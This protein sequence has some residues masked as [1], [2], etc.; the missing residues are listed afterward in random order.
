MLLEG[1]LAD[2]RRNSCPSRREMLVLAATNEH[3]HIQL[4]HCKTIQT[5]EENS[6]VFTFLYN[7]HC[8]HTHTC[9]HPL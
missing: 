4:E 9:T 5:S 3:V 8:T 2:R 7:I 6:Y 1:H